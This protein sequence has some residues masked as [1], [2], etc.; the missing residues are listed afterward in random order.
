MVLLSIIHLLRSAIE[1]VTAVS[2]MGI[3]GST[4][5]YRNIERH[6]LIMADFKAPS[7]SSLGIHNEGL[8]NQ[9]Y[10]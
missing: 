9:H 8:F 3:K 2:I 4:F 1:K 5:Y 6:H 7:L 10:L